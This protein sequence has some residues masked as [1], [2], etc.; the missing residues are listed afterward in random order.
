MKNIVLTGFMGTGKSS[1]GKLLAYRLGKSFVDIDQQIEKQMGMSIPE[2]FAKFGEEAFRAK[3]HEVVA[4]I[5]QYKNAVIATGGGVVLNARNMECLRKKGIIICLT[6]NP[7]VILERTSRRKTRPLLQ[8]DN[9]RQVIVDLLTKRQ[10][11]Y[12]QADY[13]ID[14]SALTP[15][16]VTEDIIAYLRKGGYLGAQRIR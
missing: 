10:P 9:P 4:R 2:I 1:T 5:S 13:Q 6:A 16:E 14:S 7:D 8:C 3:E 15:Y 12:D 11:F